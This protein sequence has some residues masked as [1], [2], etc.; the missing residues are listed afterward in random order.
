M[1]SF[2]SQGMAIK[3]IATH[4]KIPMSTVRTILQYKSSKQLE[5]LQIAIEEFPKG[6]LLEN[7][8]GK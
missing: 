2:I 4:L 3:K 1:L 8:S 5:L 6:S 7:Y